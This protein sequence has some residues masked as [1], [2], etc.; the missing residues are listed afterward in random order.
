MARNRAFI[1]AALALAVASC[2]P[3]PIQGTKDSLAYRLKVGMTPGQVEDII[4]PSQFQITSPTD[5]ARVCRSYIYDELIR[6]KFVHA[7]FDDG[8]LTSA[9]DGHTTACDF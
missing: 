8:L 3:G 7:Y 4:G 9:S 6:A 2:A 1:A 5:S